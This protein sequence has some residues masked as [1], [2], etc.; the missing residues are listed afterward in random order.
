MN[1]SNSN[2]VGILSMHSSWSQARPRSAS[3]HR[4]IKIVIFQI[5]K[6]LI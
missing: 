6:K 1:I 2:D 3:H 5:T 4:D